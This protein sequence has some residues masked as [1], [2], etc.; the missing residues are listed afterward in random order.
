MIST[1]S[2][3]IPTQTDRIPTQT[4]RIPTQ[5]DRIPTQSDRVPR[6]RGYSCFQIEKR[7]LEA[8]FILSST[9]AC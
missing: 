4:D 5:S 2:H 8:S 1:Q 7:A 6:D 3:R 9:S